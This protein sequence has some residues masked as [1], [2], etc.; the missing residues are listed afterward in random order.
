MEK[1]IWTDKY[2]LD[3]NVID[4]QHKHFFEIVNNIYALLE[5]GNSDRAEIIKMTDELKDYAFFHLSTEEKYFNQFFYS[6][7]TNHMKYH[8][9]FREKTNEYS[10][11]IK[12]EKED[13]P[14]LAQEM[15]DFAQTWLIKH[16]MVADKMY[17]PLFKQHGLN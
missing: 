8:T 12:N 11:R 4:E 6:D 9:M 16:I 17:A 2:K 14:K 13:L 5:K 1:F 7:M 10:D 15:A 3:I